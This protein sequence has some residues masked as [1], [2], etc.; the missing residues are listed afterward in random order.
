MTEEHRVTDPR[1]LRALAHPLRMRL[2]DELM[3]GGP[4]TATELAGVVG[5]SPA[6][7]SWHLR[8]LARYGYVEETGEGRG[9]NRPWRIVVRS[10][11]YGHSDD[12]P[13]AARIGDELSQLRLDRELA[14]LRAWQA[15]RTAEP[16]SG[17]TPRSSARASP[18]SP[19]RSSPSS[20][21]RSSS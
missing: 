13:D 2:L 16:P 7:C 18:G 12:S 8:Q 3:I 21:G 1:E 17:R 19:S 20:A 4:A 15:G 10:T 11:V 5:E 9:R 6:N 14:T